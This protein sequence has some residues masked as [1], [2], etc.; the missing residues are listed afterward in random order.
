V[1][2]AESDSQSVVDG[3][4]ALSKLKP[5]AVD[6][7][8]LPPAEEWDFRGVTEDECRVACHWEYERQGGRSTSKPGGQNM[9]PLAGCRQTAGHERQASAHAPDVRPIHR[10][11]R[12]DITPHNVNNGRRESGCPRRLHY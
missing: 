9:F 11:E 8:W 4:E 2:Q 6:F 5:Q 3:S 1:E 10:A 7:K 12:A